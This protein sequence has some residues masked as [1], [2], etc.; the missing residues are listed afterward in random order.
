GLGHNIFNPALVGRAI[1][2]VSWG[3]YMGG[4]IWPVPKMFE[5]SA[6]ISAVTT[7]TPLANQAEALKISFAQMIT[8]N[9]AGCLGETSALAILLGAFWLFYKKHIDW[10][11][12][13]GYLGTV[14]LM[15]ALFG[16]G[17]Y[18]GYLATG[19]FHLLAGGVLL[20]ALFM[21]TDLVTSPVTPAGK[22]IFGV[23]C[24]LITMMVR[25]FGTFP[26]GVTFAILIMNALTP[27]ID[28]FTI[29]R[30][31]GEVKRGA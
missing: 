13:G 21:A 11:I 5:L 1:L 19:L 2:F 26:E 9:M 23:G 7:A 8:G 16:E 20:G 30:A 6:D 14:F 15:G 25:L 17:F 10:R 29:P 31:F 4:N 18:H 28:N 3:S 22:L 27:V 24:G 12:P